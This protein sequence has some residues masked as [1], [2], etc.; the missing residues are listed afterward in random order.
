M[1]P[2]NVEALKS[3]DYH[4]VPVCL[5]NRGGIEVKRGEEIIKKNL[6]SDANSLNIDKVRTAMRVRLAF[7]VCGDGPQS[8]S[9][10]A[11]VSSLLFY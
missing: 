3:V 2:F 6:A 7:T 1:F 9:W 11:F 4:Q 8:G 10:T 5:F